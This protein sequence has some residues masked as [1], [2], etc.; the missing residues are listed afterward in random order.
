VLANSWAWVQEIKKIMSRICLGHAII[1]G[2]FGLDLFGHVE[3]TFSYL[4]P[5]IVLLHDPN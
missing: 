5:A 3:T 2:E 4:L 1:E